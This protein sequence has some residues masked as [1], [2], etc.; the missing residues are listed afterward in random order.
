[1]TTINQVEEPQFAE[2]LR[3]T[4]E[5]FAQATAGETGLKRVHKAG[6]Y[7]EDHG[8]R[9]GWDA[10]TAQ[11]EEEAE[12]ARELAAVAAAEQAERNWPADE[13]DSDD[14]HPEYL[15]GLADGLARAALGE[16]PDPLVPC[17]ACNG[18]GKMPQ[19]GSQCK[20]CFGATKVRASTL[21]V[22]ANG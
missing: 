10:K 13:E 17:K 1:M 14:D 6:R 4:E 22:E 19:W 20:T 7:G 12:A 5:Q 15:R 11:M 8:F 3:L 21:A 9:C 16:V 18:T 2:Q